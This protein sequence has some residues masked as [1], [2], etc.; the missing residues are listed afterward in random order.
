M[1]EDFPYT[2]FHDLNLDWLLEKIQEAYSPDNPPPVGLV[3]SV[4]GET[5][6]VVL[7]KDQYVRLPAIPETIWTLFRGT[8]SE[9]TEKATGIQFEKDQPMQRINGSDRYPVYD[10]GNPPPYPVSSVDGSTG[11]VKTWANSN[12][13]SLEIPAN[14]PAKVWDIMRPLD[15]GDKL[16]IEVLYDS[17]NDDY[18]AYIKCVTTGGSTERVELLSTAVI[19]PSTVVSVNGQGGIVVLSGDDIA[20]ETGGTESIAETFD[21]VKADMAIVEDTNTAQH[22]I[23]AGQYVIWKNQLYTASS[24]ITTGDTLSLANLLAVGSGGLN[25][26]QNKYNSI[27][28]LLYTGVIDENTR[29]LNIPGLT[30]Y[31]V[32]LVRPTSAYSVSCAGLAFRFP[33]LGDIRCSMFGERSGIP[34]TTAVNLHMSGNTI[35]SV[36]VYPDNNSDLK[37]YSIYGLV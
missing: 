37:I 13:A 6:A 19:P 22:D 28:K 31:W 3:L 29:N 23:Y 16:G 14:A 21:D 8:D 2:N 12:Q 34:C 7:Y 35:N 32:Y 15:N 24:N 20:T 4:N 1:F 11:A 30:D 33:L 26:L 10:S 27:G 36:D 17:V 9:N 18:K 25:D 5:G